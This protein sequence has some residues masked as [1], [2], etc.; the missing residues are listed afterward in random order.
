MDRKLGILCDCVIGADPVETLYEIKNAGFDCF[1]TNRYKIGDVEKLQT[2]AQKLAIEFEFIHA[3]FHGINALWEPGDAYLPLYSSIKEAILSASEM[4]VPVI[5]CHIS[6]GWFPPDLCDIGFQR[7]DELVSFAAQKHIV[8][9]FENLRRI[10]NVAYFADK[11]ESNDNVAFCYDCGHEHCYTETVCVPDIFR[12][13]LVCTHIHDNFG[14][15]AADKWLDGD[16][17]LLPFDGNMDY[18]KM[19]EALE[20]NRYQGSLMLEVNDKHYK[21]MTPDE[22]I[23]GAYERIKKISL[24]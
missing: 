18:K 23:T 4:G 5:V 14:R 1:F 17:H 13:K 24:M 10:G 6:S 3:P 20:R 11:Y 8:I 12:R 9:A 15:D 21:N 16:K 7:F 22:F 2:T 19:M